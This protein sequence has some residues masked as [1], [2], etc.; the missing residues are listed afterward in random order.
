MSGMIETAEGVG[1]NGS[2]TSIVLRACC[3]H[4]GGG[5]NGGWARGGFVGRWGLMMDGQEGT[6]DE[7]LI[8]Q[9]A[10]GDEEAFR[11]LI[12][13]HQDRVYG[14]VSRMIGNIGPDVEDLAQQ[15]F[16]RVW[17]AAP[18][19]QPKAKF[20]TW[21]MTVTRNLVFTY[22]ST[23]AYKMRLRDGAVNP[24][25]GEAFILE[26]RGGIAQNPRQELCT[27][28]LGEAVAA[29]YQALPESQ[30]MVLHLRQNENLGYE[31]IAIIM[32]TSTSGVKSLMFRARDFL[33]K[34]LSEYLSAPK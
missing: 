3:E 26:Q 19:F 32:K 12:E 4:E 1:V 5:D 8:T 16:L 17:K 25:T 24:D 14:T 30:R 13:R 28:E 29:A 31:E 34:E 20:T 18:R 15:I 22:C 9:M 10:G 23:Q 7:M 33:R 27:K 21:L 6:S 2:R 11:R